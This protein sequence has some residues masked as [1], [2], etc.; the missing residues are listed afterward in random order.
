MNLQN[1]NIFILGLAK[2]DNEIESTS[3]T[4]AK[5]LAAENNVFYIENPYTWKSFIF[6]KYARGIELRQKYFSFNSDQ[7]INTSVPNLKVIVSP[8]LAPINW[9][10]EGMIYRA[11]LK[12]N[13]KIILHR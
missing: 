1:K 2:F 4:I 13:E 5:H 6:K 10:P 11:A 7:L 3:F 8:P 9:L 12:L